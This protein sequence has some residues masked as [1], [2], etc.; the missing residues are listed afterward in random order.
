[1]KWHEF[2][3]EGLGGRK[4]ELGMIMAIRWAGNGD[5]NGW[6]EAFDGDDLW[7]FAQLSPVQV[8]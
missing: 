6:K 7:A 4:E 1:M 3:N 2:N 8:V 5:L